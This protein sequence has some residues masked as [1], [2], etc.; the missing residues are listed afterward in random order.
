MNQYIFQSDRLGFRQWNASDKV[1]FAAMNADPLVMEYFPATLSKEESD[2]LVDR[3]SAQQEREGFTFFAVDEL[4][5]GQFI[6][7]I[8]LSKTPYE[9]PFTPCVEI[10]WRLQKS[11]WGKG[12]ATEGAKACLRFAFE[13]LGLTEIYSFTVIGNNRS[14]NVMKKIGMTYQGTFMHPKLPDEHPMKEHV[15]YFT[16]N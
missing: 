6:G 4:E 14:E 7:F 1:P 2:S 5:S 13:K 9:T 8:G 10:G 3:I 11:A 12:Y 16:K 15:L